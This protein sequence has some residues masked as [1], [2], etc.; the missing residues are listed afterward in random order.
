MFYMYIG[1]LQMPMMMVVVVGLPRA[2]SEINGD[3]GLN[4]QIFL[5]PFI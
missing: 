3:Y 5:P 2:V 1:A 4:S